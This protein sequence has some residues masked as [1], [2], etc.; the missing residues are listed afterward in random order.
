M[1][2][3][4]LLG[5]VVMEALSIISPEPTTGGGT[6]P[7]LQDGT[8]ID[9]MTRLAEMQSSPS[10]IE[11]AHR[12]IP[13][14]PEGQR[15]GCVIAGKSRLRCV[16]QRIIESVQRASTPHAPFSPLSTMLSWPVWDSTASDR[17][18]W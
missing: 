14:Q 8:G 4:P 9:V 7:Q 5:Q 3:L 12:E 15:D 2:L 17:L 11:R 16:V 13:S 18:C 10:I 6:G 1:R